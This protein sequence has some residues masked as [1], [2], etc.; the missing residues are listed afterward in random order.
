[1]LVDKMEVMGLLWL[2]NLYDQ[3]QQAKFVPILKQI[4]Q[5]KL[6]PLEQINV[7]KYIKY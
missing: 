3:L 5:N 7:H 6:R 4:G 2:E 1:M